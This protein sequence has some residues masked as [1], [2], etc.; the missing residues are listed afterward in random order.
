MGSKDKLEKIRFS[1]GDS[2]CELDLANYQTTE[3]G[4]LSEQ[5]STFINLNKSMSKILKQSLLDSIFASI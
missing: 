3:I 1:T 4:K 5:E 2:F